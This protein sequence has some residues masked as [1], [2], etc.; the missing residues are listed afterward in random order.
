MVLFELTRYR[1]TASSYRL[2]P[3]LNLGCPLAH[4]R[5]GTAGTGVDHAD[6]NNQHAQEIKL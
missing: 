3:D 6:H 1:P 2:A 4:I 5:S